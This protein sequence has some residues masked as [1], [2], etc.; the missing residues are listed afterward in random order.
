MHHVEYESGV[1]VLQVPT[2]RSAIVPE[3][4][5]SR[6]LDRR[7]PVYWIDARNAAS[8][9]ALYDR[10][11]SP[12]S[13]STLRI[14]RAFTAYQ[15]HSLVRTLAR[16]ATERSALIVATNVVSLYRDDDLAAY[17][18]ERLCESALVTLRELGTALDVPVLATTSEQPPEILE[19]HADHTIE[20]SRTRAGVRLDGD[21]VEQVGYW[22]CAGWQTTIPYWVDLCGAADGIDPVVAAHDQGLLEPELTRAWDPT[23]GPLEPAIAEG[24]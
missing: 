12:R 4:V 18:R 14:A 20:C 2:P 7:G 11:P 5:C 1:T 15:H 21:G 16:R 9:R 3:L 19:T 24:S 8:T 6:L 17:E 23:D 13:L 10:A 22:D